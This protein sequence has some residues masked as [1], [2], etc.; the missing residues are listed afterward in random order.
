MHIFKTHGS[1]GFIFR[2]AI[3]PLSF[4]FCSMI[5]PQNAQIFKE[6]SNQGMVLD[7][8]KK[9]N[10]LINANFEYRF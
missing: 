2:N 6:N 10:F 1:L 3:D 8:T 7:F 5:L 4:R 9:Q